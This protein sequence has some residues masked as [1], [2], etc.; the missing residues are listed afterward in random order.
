MSTSTHT[1]GPWMVRSKFVGPLEIVP[2]IEG[3]A[4]GDPIAL[5]GADT[6]PQC[7]ADAELIAAAPDMLAACKDCVENR[8]DWSAAMFAAIAKAEGKV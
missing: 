7:A 1:P 2:N 3:N 8:G 6:F 4:I 5:V